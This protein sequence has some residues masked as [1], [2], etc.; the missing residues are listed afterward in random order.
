MEKIVALE[1]TGELFADATVVL[2]HPVAEDPDLLEQEIAALGEVVLKPHEI[3]HEVALVEEIPLERREHESMHEPAQTRAELVSDPR[4][5]RRRRD[6]L[7]NPTLVEIGEL[8]AMP[9]VLA[10]PYRGNVD[11]GKRI[12]D[13]ARFFRKIGD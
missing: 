4:S 1:E 10:S 11:R 5:G 12:T 6:G 13:P 3:R 9:D 8:R 7:E 2:A